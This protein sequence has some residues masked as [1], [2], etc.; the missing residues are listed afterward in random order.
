M[1]CEFFRSNADAPDATSNLLGGKG[2][3]SGLAAGAATLVV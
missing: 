2:L 1:T 3:G